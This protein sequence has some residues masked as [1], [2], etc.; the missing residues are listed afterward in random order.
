MTE[1][2]KKEVRRGRSRRL[3]LERC[4]DWYHV[5]CWGFMY[6]KNYPVLKMRNV[7]WFCTKCGKET[8][9]DWIAGEMDEDT[10]GV[11]RGRDRGERD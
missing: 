1:E 7:W 6:Q 2:C 10:G 4:K 11:L 5:A 9:K 8:R 3:A